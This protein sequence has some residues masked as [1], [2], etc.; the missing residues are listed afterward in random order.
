ME[1]NKTTVA[2]PETEAE[3]QVEETKTE[4]KVASEKDAKKQIRELKKQIATLETQVAMLETTN[5]AYRS[6]IK[7][8][9]TTLDKLVLDYTKISNYIKDATSMFHQ[10]ILMVL[11]EDK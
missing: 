10:N 7:Q 6:R 3:I 11:K 5:D 4:K 1:E 2:V 9:E 8:L